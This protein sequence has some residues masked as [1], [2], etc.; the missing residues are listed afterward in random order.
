MFPF[1]CW[2]FLVF[3]YI[4]MWNNFN[5]LMVSRLIFLCILLWQMHTVAWRGTIKTHSI[6]SPSKETPRAMLAC[7]QHTILVWAVSY[8][9]CGVSFFSSI[10]L[11]FHRL[12]QHTRKAGRE[13]G[14]A[15]GLTND[16]DT[17]IWISFASI[18][19]S[20]CT[21]PFLTCPYCS[22]WAAADTKLLPTGRLL[23]FFFFGSAFTGSVLCLFTFSLQLNVKEVW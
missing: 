6:Y 16:L 5:S 1:N 10:S 15:L 23:F 19:A 9:G 12:K 4:N 13:G 20:K 7:M 22:H 3:I 21:S 8:T 11:M 18:T 14:V 2:F 17:W